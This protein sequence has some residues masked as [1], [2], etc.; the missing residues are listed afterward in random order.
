MDDK[1]L[2]AYDKYRSAIVALDGATDL[3][4]FCQTDEY[5]HVRS[6]LNIIE[7]M[8]VG[9]ESKTLDERICYVFWYGLVLDAMASAARLIDHIQVKHKSLLFP[10]ISTA[11]L[12]LEEQSGLLFG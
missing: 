1:L 6:Y 7:L 10:G 3:E 5:H 9:I 12:S 8:A 11:A 4:L 2:L